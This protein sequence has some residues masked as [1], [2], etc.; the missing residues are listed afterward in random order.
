[1]H[2]TQKIVAAAVLLAGLSAAAPAV[3]GSLDKSRVASDAAWLIHLDV[4]RAVRSE[5]WRHCRDDAHIGQAD[6]TWRQLQEKSGFDPEQHLKDATLYGTAYAPDAAVAVIR[7]T[8][9]LESLF[10]VIAL[11]VG[12]EHR[13]LTEDGYAIHAFNV[14]GDVHYAHLASDGDVRTLVV[15]DRAGSVVRAVKVIEGGAASLDEAG[16]ARVAGTPE[17]GSILFVSATDLEALAN[18]HPESDIAT[19]AESFRFDFGESGDS[20]FATLGVTAKAEQDA[21]DIHQV[22]SGG[23]ALVRLMA[24]D[25]DRHP[26]LEPVVRLTRY[27][28]TSADARIVLIRFRAPINDV[29]GVLEEVRRRHAGRSE[30]PKDHHA[31]AEE[32][33]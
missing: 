15:A 10:D 2:R 17:D 28:S 26:E 19:Q 8:P 20:I 9:E 32:E 30:D 29:V 16:E 13:E 4:E 31:P 33:G 14:E 12:V 24:G 3:A 18:L 5:L 1:M 25:T 21:A 22:I 6:E 27:L 23:L 7:G 11:Q